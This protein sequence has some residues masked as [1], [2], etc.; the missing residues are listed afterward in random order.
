MKLIYT[1]SLLLFLFFVPSSAYAQ[2]TR[3]IKYYGV[4]RVESMN[5]ANYNKLSQNSVK[6]IVQYLSISSQS[7]WQN[8][9]TLSEKY[10][11]DIVIFPSQG[12]DIPGCGW[13]TPF[14][15]PVNGNYIGRVTTMM[16]YFDNVNNWPGGKIRVVGMVSSH[17]PMWNQDKNTDGTYKCHTQIADL[18]AIKTQLK[19]HVNRSDFKVWSYIDN[20]SDIDIIDDYSGPAD[21]EKIMDVAAIWQHCFGGA[22]GSCPNAKNKIIQDRNLLNNAGLDGRVDLVF[23]MQTFAQGG[24]YT[25]PTYNQLLTESQN[26]LNTN[27]LDGFIYYTWGAC[28]YATDLGC[29]SV[30]NPANSG[31]WPIMTIISDQFVNIGS[32]NKTGDV[33]SDGKVNILDIG[34]VVDYFG[35]NASAKPEANLNGDSVINLIDIGIVVDNYE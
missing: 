3:Q 35:S 10:N 31:L 18:A 8:L 14:N 32:S 9:I 34:I 6:T 25:M 29:P 27:A 26:F 5:D 1:L 11:M 23:L 7:A 13:E 30:S 28:W 4:D 20:I 21:Y 19:A 22:E 24:G 12:S 16:D 15:S 33:N 2:N 17:E